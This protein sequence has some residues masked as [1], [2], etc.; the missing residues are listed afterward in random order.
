MEQKEK[1]RIHIKKAISKM[2]EIQIHEKSF[3][4]TQKILQHPKIMNA[5]TI[6]IYLAKPQE[7][8]TKDI[9]WNLL[10]D[11]KNIV[12]P[13]MAWN[14]HI[15]PVRITQTSKFALGAFKIPEPIETKQYDGK[16]DVII[17]PW[18]AFSEKWERLGHWG[19]FYDTWLQNNRDVYSIWICFDIQVLWEVPTEAH[20]I[21]M[22]EI[23][24]W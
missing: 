1:I 12:V 2:T 23:V 7:I 3:Y 24:Y 15:F 19:G 4:V 21:P 10:K 6:C 13:K 11:G 5:K 16:I 9:I 8:Q 17:V 18:V 14:R 20:D 22:N